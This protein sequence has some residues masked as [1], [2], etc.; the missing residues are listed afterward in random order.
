MTTIKVSVKNK[1]DA[2]L[3]IRLLRKVSFVEQIEEIEKFE[4][5]SNQVADLKSY[6]DKNSSTSFFSDIADPISWQRNLRDE[7]K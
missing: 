1:R 2:N 4:P 3:L 5:T 7:W 6:L